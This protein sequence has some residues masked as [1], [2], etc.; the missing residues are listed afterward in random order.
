[1]K[2]SVLGAGNGGCTTAAD[3][4]RRGIPCTLFDLP[5]FE[6]VLAPIR[7]A[8]VLRL[9]G[10]FGEHTV[11]APVV[12]TDAREA[13]E[14]ADV[15]VIAIP[16]FA[17]EAFARACAPFVHPGQI[18]V[19]TPGG[20]GGALAF[21]GV[22]AREGAADGVVVAETLSL[23]Y[24]CR[25]VEPNH[26]HVGGVKQNLPVAAFPAVNTGAV[27]AALEPVFPGMLV[28]ASHVLE[29]SLNNPNAMAHPVPALLNAGWIETTGGD[30]R[31][32]TD[33]VSPSVGRAMDALD[34][35]RL[36]LMAAL[37]L[38]E[39]PAIEWDR[40]LY[41][42]VGDT[43]YEVNRDSLVHSGIRAPD[44]LRSRYLTEDVPYGLVPLASIARELGVKTPLIDLFIDLASTLLGE[45]LRAGGRT[46][47][48]L[49]LAGMDAARMV[50]Y[51]TTGRA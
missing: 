35:D 8:G 33:G 3:L 50:E 22:M 11:P 38:E 47:A 12:T 29:T 5:R 42:L 20:T 1:M 7:E 27:L 26:V 31:F 23:P 43:S 36:A 17:Q 45:D 24:A 9:T 37:G 32:Y 30:F 34:R 49:G 14:G 39:V 51:V 28:A 46:A 18:A 16:S 40:R 44:S 41:G 15:L 48:S 2:V 13:V 25:K 21:A 4:A 10:V 19:L 6:A